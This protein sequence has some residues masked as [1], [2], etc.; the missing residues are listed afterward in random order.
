MAGDYPIH[1]VV[2]ALRIT[3][4]GVVDNETDKNVAGLKARVPGS[5]NVD[6]Q[7]MVEA[8]GTK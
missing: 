7:L 8:S 6:N 2:K 4:L 3:L 1:I 5:L